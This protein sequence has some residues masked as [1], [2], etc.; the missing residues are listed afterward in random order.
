MKNM[1]LIKLPFLSTFNDMQFKVRTR[2]DR[3]NELAGLG[4]IDHFD[5]H[6]NIENPEM[7]IFGRPN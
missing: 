1:T 5:L 4:V 6:M 2:F 7:S 3:K